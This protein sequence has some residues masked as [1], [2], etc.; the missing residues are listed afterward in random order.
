MRC[1]DCSKFVGMEN[2]DLEVND[3]S[4]DTDG[5]VSVDVS[6]PRNCA[7]CSTELKRGEFQTEEQVDLE[8]EQC[9]SPDAKV[10]GEGDEAVRLHSLEIEELS[11]DVSESGGGRY[12]KNMI[13]FDLEFEV[14]CTNP[15]CELKIKGSI[16]DAMQASAF[17]ESV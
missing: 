17:D 10:E 16:G 5:Q 8:P 4:I 15:G 12:K 9:G 6:L 7:E 2:G 14:T 1:P 11:S 3:L 13:G